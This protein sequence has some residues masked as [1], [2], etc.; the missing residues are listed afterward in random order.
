METFGLQLKSQ[1]ACFS[2]Q[3]SK[4]LVPSSIGA[5]AFCLS[6]EEEANWKE[7]SGFQSY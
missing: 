6:L 3:G 1:E 4:D 5:D 2:E 7:T